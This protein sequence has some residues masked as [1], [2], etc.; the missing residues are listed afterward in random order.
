[1]SKKFK[2]SEEQYNKLI[3]EGITLNADVS[4]TNGN[5]TQAV[6]NTRQAAKESG[7]NLDNATIQVPGNP[8]EG[9]VIPMKKLVEN[10]L[11]VLK[12]HSTY[13]SFSDFIKK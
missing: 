3:D 9:K 7:V 13:Y 8:T 11:K 1:M 5:I 6:N 10:R 2:I 12:K 4:A